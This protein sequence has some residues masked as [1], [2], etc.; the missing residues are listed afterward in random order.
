MSK[1]R[2]DFFILQGNIFDTISIKRKQ[3]IETFKKLLYQRYVWLTERNKYRFYSTFQLV[4]SL[5]SLMTIL[6]AF[7]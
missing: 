4:P 6:S 3:S 1:N 7:S 5:E 2:I